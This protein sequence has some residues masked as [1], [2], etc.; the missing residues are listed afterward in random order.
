LK[1]DVLSLNNF[2]FTTGKF[3]LIAISGIFILIGINSAINPGLTFIIVSAIIY[4]GFCLYDIKKSLILLVLL[5]PIIPNSIVMDIG[6]G[7]SRIF[8]YRI[9]LSVFLL[10]YASAFMM[11]KIN[12]KW[13]SYHK[14]G[15]L[16]L[17]S[18]VLNTLFSSQPLVSLKTSVA[19]LW[20]GGL[21]MFFVA[22]HITEN[23][24]LLKK[25]AIAALISAVLVSILGI[26]E[27]LSGNSIELSMVVSYLSPLKGDITIGDWGRELGIRGGF[28]RA[29]ATMFHPLGMASY[30]LFIL[31]LVFEY[32]SRG[33]GRWITFFTIIAGIASTLSRAGWFI[34]C[35]IL[36]FR[37]RKNI[38]LFVVMGL[39]TILLIIPW[40]QQSGQEGTNMLMVANTDVAR[41]I[42]LEEALKVFK[43]HP[44]FG[45]GVGHLDI[46]VFENVQYRSWDVTIA[47]LLEENGMI[48]VSIWLTFFLYLT[49]RFYKVSKNDKF[50]ARW[51]AEG[52]FM[53]I[54]ASLINATF[55]N[56]IFQFSQGYLVMMIL[57][58]A[59]ARREWEFR[60]KNVGKLA[61]HYK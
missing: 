50:P 44:F 7:S 41:F 42:R 35:A 61:E 48:G 40:Y 36:G 46:E 23:E 53:G 59:L 32:V 17:L 57:L 3:I 24:V 49:I 21:L 2:E 45:V 51:I 19:E 58:G 28:Y 11:G 13:T 16:F 38:I 5:I 39:L 54:I 43:A 25:L 8:F 20:G 26:Y 4:A 56:S 9:L 15:L 18:I 31:P 37:I 22:F 14:I 6:S 30:L 12:L 29:Q 47:C 52:L 60:V 10:T 27:T 33:K 1:L 55:S 34:G